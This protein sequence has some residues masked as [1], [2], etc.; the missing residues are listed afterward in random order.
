MYPRMYVGD[1]AKATAEKGRALAEARVEGMVR[2]IRA[3][4][5]DAVTEGLIDTFMR[6]VE[7]PENPW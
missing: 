5:E 2:L 7:K 4:K 3:V 6:G 1:A